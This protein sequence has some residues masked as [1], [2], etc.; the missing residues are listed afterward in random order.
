[1]CR[2][3]IEDAKYRDPHADGWDYRNTLCSLLTDEYFRLESRV[4]RRTRERLG[5]N[6]IGVHKNNMELYAQGEEK[7]G[8]RSRERLLK[9][10]QREYTD[11]V[12][13]SG[14]HDG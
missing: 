7:K 8:L 9:K 4:R 13:D 10:R 14:E 11:D 12:E 5:G 1:M 3:Y 6:N 2:V